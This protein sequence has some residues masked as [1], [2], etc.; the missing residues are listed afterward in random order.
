MRAPRQVRLETIVPEPTD[1][2]RSEIMLSTFRRPGWIKM[3]RQA[4]NIH[5]SRVQRPYV[6]ISVELVPERRR[7]AC[8]QHFLGETEIRLRSCGRVRSV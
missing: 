1:S 5:P 3:N 6:G 2:S 7:H 4:I 8:C